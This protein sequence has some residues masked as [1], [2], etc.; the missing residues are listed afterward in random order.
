MKP[1]HLWRG[2]VTFIVHILDDFS[3]PASPSH[4]TPS[5]VMEGKH[6]ISRLSIVF[7]NIDE[8]NLSPVC[9]APAKLIVHDDGNFM[10]PQRELIEMPFERRFR[11]SIYQRSVV[12]KFCL[13][14][15]HC[16]ILCLCPDP[17]IIDDR[18][19]EFSDVAF[20]HSLSV[21]DSDSW[22]DDAY[23]GWRFCEI[24]KVCKRSCDH[25]CGID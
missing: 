18:R 15:R 2:A 4:E 10:V 16:S 12:K 25:S 7:E 3:A 1:R 24:S 9:R 6:H 14:N 23:L 11:I 21:E 8:S 13:H 22:R 20:L 5:L 17:N 19:L